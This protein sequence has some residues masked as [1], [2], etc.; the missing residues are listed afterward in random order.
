MEAEKWWSAWAP[1]WDHIEDRHFGTKTIKALID[2][3][4]SDVLIIG[5]GQGLIVR[6]LMNKGMNAVGLDINPHITCITWQEFLRSM[7]FR[8]KTP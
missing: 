2:M 8:Q 1:V 7:K 5:A 4:Q 6:Y 3:I